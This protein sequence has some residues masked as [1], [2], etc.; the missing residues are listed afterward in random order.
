[1]VCIMKA[2]MAFP[3]NSASITRFYLT[4]ASKWGPMSIPY[5]PL[6]LKNLKEKPKSPFG[7]TCFNKKGYIQ[8]PSYDVSGFRGLR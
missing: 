3:I 6:L 2:S 7:L 1:M 5:Q 8:L 4:Y